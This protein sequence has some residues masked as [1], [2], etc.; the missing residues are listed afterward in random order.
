MIQ[1]VCKK[2]NPS[3]AVEHVQGAAEVR[4]GATVRSPGRVSLRTGNHDVSI[5]R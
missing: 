5:F 2:N 3:D 4:K 1:K